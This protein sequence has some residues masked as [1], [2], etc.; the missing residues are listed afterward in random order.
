M[1]IA[2]IF[3]SFLILLAA[4][5]Y[6]PAFAKDKV[7]S[8]DSG[9]PEVDGD[10]QDPTDKNVRVRVFVHKV[11]NH[12]SSAALVCSDPDSSA[13]TGWAGWKLPV[14]NWTYNL[15]PSSVPSSVGAAN[16][17]TIASNGFGA[18]EAAQ[19]KVDFVAGPT[20]T[21]A[22]SSYE[23]KNVIAWGRTSGSALGVTYVR[24]YT[25]SRL[26]VDVDTIMNKKFPWS[27]NGGSATTCGD[28]NTY[29]AQNI[30]V[31]EQGHW[32]GL[33]DHYDASYVNNTLYGYGSKG[34]TKKNTPTTGDV[35]GIAAI[36]P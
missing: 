17:A 5:V 13:T 7:E 26:V 22:R 16:L 29:D 30:L 34:E 31:H 23:G 19:N 9:I 28:P 12:T 33:N 24:Y 14:G 36:Y 21:I 35:A 4:A 3:L 10:Y 15:N 6:L 27:W 1:K 8:N 2:S 18:W 25:A 20:T 11:K 32:M